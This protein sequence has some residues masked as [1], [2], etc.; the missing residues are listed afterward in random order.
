MALYQYLQPQN[1]LPGLN[2]SL[3]SIIPSQA[4]AKVNQE[5]MDA[6]QSETRNIH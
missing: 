5:V 6:T 4:I 3:S 2:G 1:W